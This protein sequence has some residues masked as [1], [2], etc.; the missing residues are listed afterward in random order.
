MKLKLIWRANA[1]VIAIGIAIAIALAASASILVNL[2]Q[3]STCPS[4]SVPSGNICVQ[5]Y[6]NGNQI[7]IAGKKVVAPIP[8]SSAAPTPVV[9]IS[10]LPTP[11]TARPYTPRPYTPRPYTPRPYTPR[12]YTPRPRVIKPVAVI[13]SASAKPA[14][15][16]YSLTQQIANLIPGSQIFS[17]PANTG[18]AGVA[19]YFWSSAPSSFQTVN[20]ILGLGIGI[21]LV[22]TF[23]WDYGDGTTVTAGSSSADGAGIGLASSYKH[24]YTSAGWYQVRLITNWSGAWSMAGSSYTIGG[25]ALTQVATKNIYIN[26]APT[27]VVR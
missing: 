9:K 17:L 19:N 26:P 11:N 14:T 16:G 1:F 5:V 7:I 25:S 6:A 8:A 12:P 20:Q 4:G 24:S 3:A 27:N 10:H 22:P 18:I 23:T 13:A 21:N 15:P 2:A